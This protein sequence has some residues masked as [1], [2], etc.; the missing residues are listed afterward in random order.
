MKQSFFSAHHL[1]GA[2][3]G[4]DKTDS[5]IAAFFSVTVRMFLLAEVLVLALAM[6]LAVIRSL[7]GP[8][9]FPFRILAIIYIDF[10]RGIPLLLLMFIVGLGVP[11]MQLS[12]LSR[13]SQFVYGVIALTLVYSGLRRGG[14]SGGDRVRA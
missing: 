8:V 11:G 13:Q 1:R 12:A 4:T 7:P 6:F 3:F 2:A 5:V 10:F 14:V 9:F